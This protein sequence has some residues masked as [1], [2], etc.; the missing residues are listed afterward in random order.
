M[1]CWT[2]VRLSRQIGLRGPNDSHG[3]RLH[4]FRHAFAVR[5]LV[6]W[7]RD[8]LDVEQH[9]PELAAYLGHVNVSNTYWYL[10]AI[11]ELLHLATLRLE[12]GGLS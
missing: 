9:L 8:G 6:Q 5:T 11:P 10:S 7:Y 1:A 2:F 12:G 3:P 4:D